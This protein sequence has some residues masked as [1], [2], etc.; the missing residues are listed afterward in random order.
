[1]PPDL[2][3][4]GLSLISLRVV[5]SES[6]VVRG[7]KS[8]GRENPIS[9]IKVPAEQAPFPVGAARRMVPHRSGAIYRGF[10]P[11]RHQRM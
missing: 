7:R 8:Y 10:E 6:I 11:V 4:P 2:F 9:G 3:A 5:G 1:M